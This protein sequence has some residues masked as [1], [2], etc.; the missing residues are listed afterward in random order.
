MCETVVFR[1][2]GLYLDVLCDT[3]FESD[4]SLCGATMG[5]KRVEIRGNWLCGKAKQKRHLAHS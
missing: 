4:E 5:G 3:G 2:Q 1:T